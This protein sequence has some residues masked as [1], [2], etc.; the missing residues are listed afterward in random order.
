MAT[1][2]F[3]RWADLGFADAIIP[4]IPPLAPLANPANRALASERGKAP[5]LKGKS[6]RWYG[7]A[8]WRTDP[9]PPLDDMDSWGANLGLRC[10]HL[11]ALDIDCTDEELTAALVALARHVL[12]PAK[13]RIGR[14]PK[15]LL[16]FAAKGTLTKR[17]LA[18]GDGHAIEVL[19]E[20]QQFVAAGTHPVTMRPYEWPEGEPEAGSL[21]AIDEADVERFLGGADALLRARGVAVGALTRLPS[22]R[23]D[24]DQ[25][26]L[27]APSAEILAEAVAAMPN[28]GGYDDWIPG[29]CAIKAAAAGLLDD[30]GRELARNWTARW[31]GTGQGGAH[32]DFDTKWNQQHPPYRVGWPWIELRARGAGWTGSAARDFAGVIGTVEIAAAKTLVGAPLT[33]DENLTLQQRAFRDFVWIEAIERFGCLVDGAILSAKQFSVRLSW[34]GPPLSQSKS[35]AAQFLADP[36]CRRVQGV[37]YHPGAPRLVAEDGVGECFNRWRPSSLVPQAGATSDDVRPWLD[38]AARL[39]PEEATRERVLDWAAAIVQIQATKINFALVLGGLPGIGKDMMFAPVVRLLGLH[40]V[41]VV[42]MADIEAPQNDWCL[43]RMVVVNEAHSMSRVAQMEKLK[44]HIA[45]PPWVV[46]INTKNVPQYQIP[47]RHV[48]LFFTNRR[49]AVTIEHGD[50]RYMVV[51]SEMEKQPEAY[52]RGLWSWLETGG[53]E[54]VAGYLLARDLGARGFNPHGEAPWTREKGDMQRETLSDVQSAVM[55]AIES[56]EWP[57]LVNPGDLA[58][59]LNAAAGARGRGFNGKVVASAL[60]LAGAKA[61]NDG[62]MVRLPAP[63][64]T[65]TDRVRLLSIRNHEAYAAKPPAFLARAFALSWAEKDGKQFSDFSPALSVVTHEDLF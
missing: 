61:V 18:F 44:P 8:K 14:A 33:D 55:D 15:A 32:I 50:R 4:V 31:S 48:M 21:V 39:I 16:L 56:G 42:S 12:G 43:A 49:D 1:G 35:A 9:A 37:T 27:V 2:I 22:M 6:G 58:A 45:A 52:Y 36:R 64:F 54:A 26:T 38:H 41:S 29:L 40:N 10:D 13:V 34:W 63:C 60:R 46:R 23:D 51:W 25:A 30:D 24:V 17:R 19:A 20:G 3:R 62:A 7:W 47:N 28:D 11:R 53:H 5:G 59:R 65:G 57:D